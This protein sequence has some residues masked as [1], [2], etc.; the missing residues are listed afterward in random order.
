MDGP[1]GAG[2]GWEGW[3]A[4]LDKGQ[5]TAAILNVLLTLEAPGQLP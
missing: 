2:V 5:L 4:S 3:P 1:P